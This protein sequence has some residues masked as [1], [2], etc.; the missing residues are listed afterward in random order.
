MC[1]E[2]KSVVEEQI[3]QGVVHDIHVSEPVVYVDNQARNRSGHMS[4]AMVELSD[5]RIID[6]NSNCSAERYF[7]HTPFGWIEYRYSDDGGASFGDVYDLP[8]TKQV[9]DDGI[10]TISVEKAVLCDDGTLI[11]FCLRN[12]AA[13]ERH[14]C[15]PWATPMYVRSTDGGATWTKEAELS[16]Y[17]GRTYGAINQ[18]GTIYV[19]HFCNERFRGRDPEHLYRLYK[20]T[21]NGKHFFEESVVDFG[22]TFGLGY[23]SLTFMADGRLVAYAQDLNAPEYLRYAISNDNGKSWCEIGKSYVKYGAINPQ[24]NVLDGQYIM[25]G[26][27]A[28]ACDLVLYTS[29]DGLHWD[30]GHILNPKKQSSGCFY[31]NNVI[32]HGYGKQGKDH[33][34]VQFSES[35]YSSCVNAMHIMIESC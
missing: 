18:N 29:K 24:I 35:Y 31:S 13:L 22:N 4:H 23:G 7:G 8:Y 19:L 10:M 12:N 3:I 1:M 27:S 20:S 26:R 25:H 6:F 2:F 11:A 34:I 15:E 28:F 9:F 17:P 32:A 33:M 21:D 16:P 30:E 5:G 14:F